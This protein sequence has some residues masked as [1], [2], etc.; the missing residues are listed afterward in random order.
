MF[1]FFFTRGDAQKPHPK[2][3]SELIIFRAV[4]LLLYKWG[5][6]FHGGVDLNN[7]LPDCHHSVSLTRLTYAHLSSTSLCLLSSRLFPV[8]HLCP[9]LHL[10]YCFLSF[11]SLTLH[12]SSLCPATSL[13][14]SLPP[15]LHYPPPAPHLPPPLLSSPLSNQICNGAHFPKK[16]KK[17]SHSIATRLLTTVASAATDAGGGAGM[18]NYIRGDYTL[19]Q[20]IFPVVSR[21]RETTLSLLTPSASLL[22]S[23]PLFSSLSPAYLCISPSLSRT[24]KKKER[25]KKW[26][27]KSNPQAFRAHASAAI[28]SALSL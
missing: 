26:I 5:W 18:W 1:F 2:P 13:P 14:P 10:L 28:T 23:S 12:L 25:K 17:S 19:P 7:T 16:K 24:T 21:G 8:P 3:L 9:S 4:V 20:L 6:S 11:L 15:D 27:K 22:P